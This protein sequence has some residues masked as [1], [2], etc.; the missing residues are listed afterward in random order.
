MHCPHCGAQALDQAKFCVSCGG[1]LQAAAPV[2]AQPES[3]PAAVEV[4]VQP[5]AQQAAP[6]E[7]ASQDDVFA[8]YE[9]MLQPE[10]PMQPVG[11]DAPGSQP[12]AFS[13]TPAPVYA[14]PQYRPQPAMPGAIYPMTDTDRTLRLIAFVFSVV[15]LVVF[16][17][18]IF[19][20][21]W[22]IPMTVI[23]WGIYKG[24]KRNTT[25]FA[26]CSLL[27]LSIV[28]GILLLC[29]HKDS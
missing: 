15:S 2:D 13:S 16:A 24:K 23:T 11:M 1:S 19:P 3:Q 12:Q 29:S 7:T 5:A 21:I 25:A 8:N 28:S 14:Q 22:A 27:F 18:A 20:L 6:V 4:P 10:T 9:P 17:P 26:V